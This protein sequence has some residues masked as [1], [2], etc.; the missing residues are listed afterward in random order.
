MINNYLIDD[1]ITEVPVQEY[2]ERIELVRKKMTEENYD[3]LIIYSNPWHL[4]NVFWLTN[5]RAFDGIS[6]DP[7]LLYLPINGD[8]IL[9]CESPIIPYCKD[10]TWVEDIRPVRPGFEQLLKALKAD[11]RCK[12]VGLVGAQYFALEFYRIIEAVLGADCLR[13]TDI[14]YKLKCIKSENDIHIMRNA[15][16]ITDQSLLDLK[17]NIY[18]G[19]TEREAVQVMQTS[20]FMHGAD[21]QAFDVMVQSGIHAGKYVLA[22]GTEKKI[23]KGELLLIDTGVRYRNYACDM[24]RGFAYGDINDD[25]QRLLDVSL[26]AFKAG[27]PFLKPG[28]SSSL[29]SK[30]IDQVLNDNG[31]GS[32][33]TAAGNRKCGHGLGNDPEEEYPV[34][35]R[36]DHVLQENM[37]IAYELTVQ[38]PELGGCRVEDMVIIRKDGPEFLTN[39]ARN[40]RWD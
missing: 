34:M 39:F 7:A 24:G 32:M 5:F 12:N 9:F 13:D 40:T 6:P 17:N 14:I 37:C 10:T 27:I 19:M 25:Q 20:L 1:T 30:A 18:D 31:F 11:G 16:R 38:K 28:L 4:S 15:A 36:T 21:S 22:R 8:P 35:G 26:E 33:H 29:A 23:R 2:K 3:S